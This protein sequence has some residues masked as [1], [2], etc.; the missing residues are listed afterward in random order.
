[1]KYSVLISTTAEADLV[2]IYKWYEFQ[3]T[4]LGDEFM[5]D[6]E[7]SLQSLSEFP[8]YQ[9]RY[10]EIRYKSLHRFPHLIHYRLFE[11]TQKVLVEAVMHPS[12]FP[13]DF[14]KG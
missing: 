11:S 7:R 8:H 10:G 3:R 2:E 14:R 13:R 12:Q 4:G 9:L 1:M 6:F 5:T